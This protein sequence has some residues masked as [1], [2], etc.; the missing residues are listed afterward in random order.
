[1]K[2]LKTLDFRRG[3]HSFSFTFSLVKRLNILRNIWVIRFGAIC[4]TIDA[5]NIFNLKIYLNTEILLLLS[6][7][8]TK[9]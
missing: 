6:L 4:D 5:L 9:I 8:L 3:N 2:V 7:H 1:M